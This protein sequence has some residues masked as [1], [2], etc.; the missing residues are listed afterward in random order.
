MDDARDGFAFGAAEGAGSEGGVMGDPARQPLRGPSGGGRGIDEVQ[1]ERAG[2]EELF[3][4]GHL[5]GRFRGG[6]HDDG[7]V[8][9]VELAAALFPHDG[10]AAEFE[11]PRLAQIGPAGERVAVAHDQPPRF[12]LAVV[13]HAEGGLKDGFQRGA[14]GGGGDHRL[15]RVGLAGGEEGEGCVVSGHLSGPFAGGTVVMRRGRR[16][17]HSPCLACARVALR[18]VPFGYLGRYEGARGFQRVA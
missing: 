9:A 13:G 2:G 17:P 5:F 18:L 14:V 12:E 10:V 7:K 11:R 4:R 1:A 16:R 8:G 6:D 3:G 15:G